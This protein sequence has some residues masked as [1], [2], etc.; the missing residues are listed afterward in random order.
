MTN[1]AN[2]FAANIARF[3]G[4]A[5]TYDNFRPSPPLVLR[6][7]LTRFVQMERP[8]LV[9]D[10]G[11]G[12]GLSTRYWS[13]YA[14]QVIGVDPTEDMLRQ[15]EERTTDPQIAYRVGFSHDTGLPDDCADVVTAS[16]SLHWMDPQPTFKEIAR[17]LR[18]GGVF[19]AYDY[20]WPPTTGEWRADAAYRAFL[21]R[22]EQIERTRGVSD[23]LKRWS[24]SG[25][26]SRMSESG[27]FRYTAEIAVHHIETGDAERFIGLAL[28]QGSLETLLKSGVSE[29]EVGL[30][31]FRQTAQKTLGD[32]PRNWYFTSRV[33]IGVL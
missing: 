13:D 20:D 6:E 1:E 7:I 19:A 15:A 3:S 22:V 23:Q 26:L 24:K 29:A 32:T 8:E 5:D 21:E 18:P 33:R 16:Q 25:H 4:F 11:C 17:I 28:S 14:E 10:L 12:T 2:E 30:D 31:T 9:V 27:R